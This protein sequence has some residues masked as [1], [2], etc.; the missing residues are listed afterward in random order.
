MNFNYVIVNN[1][2]NSSK[3]KVSGYLTPS[4]N[5]KDVFEVL[6]NSYK[7]I[8]N[9]YKLDSD[10]MAIKDNELVFVDISFDTMINFLALLSSSLK[11][12]II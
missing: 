3:Y 2:D 4:E 12:N 9:E 6:K 1:T 8:F 5:D 11:V 10:N 7:E